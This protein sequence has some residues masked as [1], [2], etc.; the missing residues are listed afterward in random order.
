MSGLGS[1]EAV[2]DDRHGRK[3][4][5]AVIGRFWPEAEWQLWS[6]GRGKLPVNRHR[7]D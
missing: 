3:A 2:R 1:E 6:R 7:A 5:I 4:V